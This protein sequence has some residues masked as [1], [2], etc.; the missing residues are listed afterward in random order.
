MGSEP[1]EVTARDVELAQEMFSLG[2]KL[3][4]NQYKDD[5]DWVAYKKNKIL[6]KV[7][8]DAAMKGLLKDIFECGKA[9]GEKRKQDKRTPDT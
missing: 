4:K 2:M 1:K 6:S 3:S 8:N 7:N 5:F 9:I